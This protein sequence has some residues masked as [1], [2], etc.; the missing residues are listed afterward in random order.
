[1]SLSRNKLYTLLIVG[2][3]AG[4][5]WLW[6]S[7]NAV[8]P[9]TET[10]VCIFKHVTSIPCPSCGSTRSILSLLQGDIKSSIMW[11]PLGIILLGVLFFT[12]VWIVVDIFTRR[13]SLYRFAGKAEALLNKRWVAIPAT[14]LLM[15]NWVWN[16][17]KGL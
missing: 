17:Y 15:A 3:F 4:Y 8:L 14:I 2:S 12:H 9:S 6:I 16:I 5:T 11:N 1:M 13:D 7:F 10:N